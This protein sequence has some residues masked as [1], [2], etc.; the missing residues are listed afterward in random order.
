MDAQSCCSGGVPVSGNLGLPTAEKG[1]SQVS[2]SYDWNVLKTL[3]EGVEKL[4]DQSR[5]RTT[6]SA[7][8]EI[9]HT[10]TNR[11]STDFFFSFLQQIRA[12]RQN[13]QQ[14]DFDQTSGIGD[15][16]ALFKYQ[17]LKGKNKGRNLQLGL[18]PKI[19]LGSFGNKDD[20]GI[21]LSADLQPGSGA[22]DMIF[23]GQFTQQLSFRPSSNLLLSSTYALKGENPRFN[24]IE[25]YA[26]GEEWLVSIGISDRMVLFNKL[27]DP[28]LLFRYR[29]VQ[30]DFRN[31]SLL[32]S[33][34]GEW[35]YINPGI[36]FWFS[37]KMSYQINGEIPLYANLIGTQ[38]TP[39]YRF[40][41]GLY[42][43]F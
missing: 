7:L 32:P 43:R 31:G 29:Q 30:P 16:V 41:T 36:T 22:W 34:G 28:S 6:H 8:L 20:R 33:S 25:T 40:N 27:V 35:V 9:G 18:G 12:I 38:I 42:W 17:V 4:E 10:W 3:K 1:S 21:T 23:W 2:L 26:F 5:N 39:T 37:E 15:A 14:T 19:P 13:G 11:F 24:E